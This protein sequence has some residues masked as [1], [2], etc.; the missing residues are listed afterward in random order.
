MINPTFLRSPNAG[1]WIVPND[2]GEI[3]QARIHVRDGALNARMEAAR[4]LVSDLAAA[5]AERKSRV[6]TAKAA[7]S[8][9][10]AAK[11]E[12]AKASKGDDEA[13][14]KEAASAVERAEDT[15][16]TANFAE[17]GALGHLEDARRKARLAPTRITTPAELAAFAKKAPA[18]TTFVLCG[19]GSAVSRCDFGDWIAAARE[20]VRPESA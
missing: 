13:A 16:A 1:V 7:S 14:K 11:V 6:A 19:P 17:R 9:L 8:A 15:L 2:R 12:A 18:S 3:A 20:V 4:A 5:E 10:D